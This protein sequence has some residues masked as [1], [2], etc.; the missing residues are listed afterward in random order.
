MSNQNYKFEATDLKKI[1]MH[2]LYISEAKYGTDW[3]SAMHAHHFMELFYIV[4]GKGAFLI[5][6][7]RVP[8]K[9]GDLVIIN[10]NVSHTETGYDDQ[11][12]EY[13][14]LGINGLYFQNEQDGKS[15][16]Y[17]VHNF[18]KYKDDLYFYLKILIKE[19]Q[20]K[21]DHFED[22]CQ[23]LSE[24]LMLNII[25]NTKAE[26]SVAPTQK[27]TKECYFIEQ[28]LNE[29]F[30]EDITLDTLGSLT[31][32]NKYYLVH[33]FKKYKGVSPINYMIDKRIQESKHLLETT[34]YPISRIATLIG[35]SSQSYFSQVFRKATDMTP[36]EYRKSMQKGLSKN[37]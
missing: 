13:I 33:A 9:E 20:D 1:D 25:R 30:K 15:R 17:S 4:H 26:F 37:G 36:N 14:V 12:F 2:L 27:I 8:A 10:P 3:H 6:N 28:Y 23:N 22:I 24:I 11:P 16:N 7:E 35:F 29:H 32:L 31:Y 19:I 34:N 5:E 18:L 21:R